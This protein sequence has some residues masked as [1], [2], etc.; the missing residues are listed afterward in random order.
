MQKTI[1]K[2][3]KSIFGVVA[4]F[5]ILSS[6]VSALT[7][8]KSF[9][10]IGAGASISVR[11]GD[12]Y[13]FSVSGTFVGTV[14]L[15]K[16][17]NGGQSWFVAKKI[18]ATL[19]STTF[20]ADLAAGGIAQYRFRCDS[21]TSG[22]IV[23]S[24]ANAVKVYFKQSDDNGN[25][26]FSIDDNGINVLAA[27]VLNGGSFSSG[28]LVSSSANPAASGVIRLANTDA[29][30]FRNSGNSADIAL[31]VGS[32]DGILSYNGVD[33]S[34][35]SLTQTL[36]NKTISGSSNTLSNI[37][38]GSLSSSYIKADGTRSLSG[39]W[40]LGNFTLGVAASAS[41]SAIINVGDS[42][43]QPLIGT[44]QSALQL[45]MIGTSAATGS[46]R[47]LQSFVTTAASTVVPEV[48]S[49]RAGS[50]VIGAS[51]SVTRATGLRVDAQN[52]S[53]IVNSAAIADNL[54]YA[55]N[56]FINYSGSLKSSIAGPVAFA[57]TTTNDSASG[58]FVGEQIIASVATGSAVSLSTGTAANV[59][60]VSL[61]AGDW[62]VSGCIVFKPG[63]T[64]SI[65]LLGAA[66]SATTNAVPAVIGQN[67]TNDFL[68]QNASA[69]FVPGS[70]DDT[71]CIPPV[72][73]SLSTTTTTYL[74]GKATF[75][76]STLAEYGQIRA[77]R[78]R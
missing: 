72:R 3:L 24:I 64:T 54:A 13:T 77:R 62:D 65:T 6:D 52:I 45:D 57:G 17:Q 78:M 60:S 70:N 18:S 16:S 8:S 31:G 20:T 14:F 53:G 15:E 69:A 36:S 33:L 38:D 29:I 30:K 49:I 23:T 37:A 40:A 21:Y 1:F 10:A 19:A 2:T 51:G 46:V 26:L 7:I 44:N 56:Y 58:G 59:T 28:S 12:P 74:V 63:A 27:T 66:I 32:A 55:G 76:I 42:G 67:S 22:T 34:G 39:S 61:T 48:S 43:S 68:V 47:G 9:T 4:L 35:I 11:S 75:S 50:P 71:L 73:V 5:G 41:G 25:L